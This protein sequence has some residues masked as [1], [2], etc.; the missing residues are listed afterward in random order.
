MVL[1]V[2]GGVTI[3]TVKLLLKDYKH[4]IYTTKSHTEQS[5][6]FRVILPLSHT[7]KLSADDYKEFCNNVYEWLPFEVDNGT[8]QRSRKWRTY[9]SDHW[10][11][12]GK[13]LDAL[14]FIPKTSKSEERKKIIVDQQSLS[15]LERW[16]VA[17]TGSGNRN[18]QYL[19]YAL[20]LVDSGMDIDSIQNNVLA[21]NDKLPNKI[22]EA[23]ILST[24]M[25]S[26]A[27]A[28]IKRDSN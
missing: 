21:L 27:K 11:N 1:D 26:T 8:N 10:Y 23:E 7:L 2:D 3:D 18:N 5:H 12:D 24:I 4:L 16:F 9:D 20:V 28:I 22:D 6:R 17:N 25:R 19:K 15:N 14:L 13:P